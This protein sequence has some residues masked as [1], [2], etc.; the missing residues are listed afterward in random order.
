MKAHLLKIPGQNIRVCS[1]IKE[2]ILME[3]RKLNKEAEA[4]AVALVGRTVS[5]PASARKL[6]REKLSH[7]LKTL[8]FG[9]VST[10]YNIR[11]L[12]I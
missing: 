6:L 1:V 4:R 7:F 3:A 9:N 10:T 11:L 2:P 8:S 12:Y 5:L